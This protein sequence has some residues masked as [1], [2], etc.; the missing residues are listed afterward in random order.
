MKYEHILKKVITKEGASFLFTEKNS[1]A[2]LNELV[3]L[4]LERRNTITSVLRALEDPGLKEYGGNMM[5]IRKKRATIIIY[6]WFNHEKEDSG[7]EI[8][9]EDLIKIF[10]A[11][12]EIN[13]LEK[14]NGEINQLILQRDEEHVYMTAHYEDGSEF[15]RTFNYK[16][17]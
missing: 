15:R 2:Y 17:E 7:I 8:N 11:W 13:E 3:L 10:E 6:N 1:D 4:L 12:Q 9:Q 14:T 16:T 5:Y